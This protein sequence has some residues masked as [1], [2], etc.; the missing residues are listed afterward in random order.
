M[1]CKYTNEELDDAA[2]RD[3]LNDAECAERQASEGPFYPE[4]DITPESLLKYAAKC[5]AQAQKY[6]GG[7]A[8]N[9]VL[10]G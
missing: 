2:L 6:A 10:K 3:I 7:G 1:A 4:K 5:R 8:H 9:F